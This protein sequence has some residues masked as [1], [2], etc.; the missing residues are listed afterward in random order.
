M[1]HRMLLLSALLVLRAMPSGA[2]AVG[3]SRGE[4]RAEG[5]QVRADLVFARK[6][7]LTALPNLDA[8]RDGDLSSGEIE[9][10]RGELSEWVRRG[11]VGPSLFRLGVEH[12]LT[13]YDHLLFLLALVLVGGPLRS[14]LGVVTAFTLAHSVTLAVA[15]LGVWVPRPTLIE[16]A[17][18]LSI[19][20]VGIE[21][22]VRP[23]MRRRW[24]LTFLFGLV[25][26]FGFAGAL[27]EVA[28]SAVQIPLALA[29]F[30]VGVEAGQLAVLAVVLPLVSW[31]GGRVW[32]AGR[33]VQVAS[34]AIS[35][36]GLCWFVVRVTG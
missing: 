18:A 9:H 22:C 12:I 8:D 34:I 26:G 16:P 36:I 14:V 3:V 17:I 24:R 25:H 29:S 19:A 21:N 35:A 10:A 1:L 15:A 31:L 6:E 30:N 32:F 28:L 23:D 4:Y 5:A 20:Y 27:R 11:I 7:L 13:G 2:H 33:G